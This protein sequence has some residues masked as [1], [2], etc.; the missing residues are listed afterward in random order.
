[1]TAFGAVV[2]KDIEEVTEAAAEAITIPLPTTDTI[3]NDL[4]IVYISKDDPNPVD[5]HGDWIGI[6]NEVGTGDQ[7]LYMAYRIVTQ[8]DLD[9]EAKDWTWTETSGNESWIGKILTYRGAD[10]G[11]PIH[12]S[13]TAF[14]D[15]DA[16]P[17]APSVAFENLTAGSLVLQVFGCDDDDGGYVV[18]S[19]LTSRFNTAANNV[20]GAGGDKSSAS[21]SWTSPTGFVDGNSKWTSEE[22]AYDEDTADPARNG[23]ETGWTSYL[24]LTHSAINCKKV[25]FFAYYSATYVTQISV[26]VYYSSDWHNIYEGIFADS[27]WV[28]KEI[29]SI[30]SV[31]A[32]RIKLYV[33]LVGNTELFEVDFGEVTGDISG[34][35]NTGTAVFEMGASEEWAAATVII[36]AESVAGWTGKFNTKTI[37]KWNTKAISKLNTK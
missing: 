32:M 35:G 30:Q 24:E 26:D 11:S 13:D 25:R 15:A 4:L 2:Y 6:C 22:D 7:T 23:T 17:I 14:L 19:P 33:L 31:T 5:V 21:F 12:D 18:P 34:S 9:A 29:G 10:T 28:E 37:S 27:E 3:L 36:E 8:A 1:M 16:A 20:G